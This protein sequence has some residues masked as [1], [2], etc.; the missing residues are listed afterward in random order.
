MLFVCLGNVLVLF[1]PVYSILC[2]ELD[3]LEADMGMETKSDGVPSYLQPDRE[4]DIDGELNLPSAPIGHAAVPAGR[5]NGQVYAL[6]QF[7]HD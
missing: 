4:S 1:L 3:A 2:P 7:M 5:T 6:I